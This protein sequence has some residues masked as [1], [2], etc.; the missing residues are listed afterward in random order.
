MKVLSDAKRLLTRELHNLIRERSELDGQI[1][2][3]KKSIEAMDYAEKLKRIRR[4]GPRRDKGKKKVQQKDKP[5][6]EKRKHAV[7]LLPGDPLRAS[8]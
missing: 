6:P 7:T 1:Y 4:A 2:R 8:V 5:A 3:L